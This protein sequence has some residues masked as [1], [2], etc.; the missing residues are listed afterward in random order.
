MVL[1]RLRVCL[2]ETALRT[3]RFG[4]VNAVYLRV[5]FMRNCLMSSLLKL[6]AFA[7]VFAFAASAQAAAFAD[8]DTDGDGAVTPDEFVAAYPTLGREAWEIVDADENGTL[9]PQEHQAGL[10]AGVLPQA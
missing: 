8:V 2:A 9:S 6:G 5:Y 10:D 7:L 1:P 3:C 4:T